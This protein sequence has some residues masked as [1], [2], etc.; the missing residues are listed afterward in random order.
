MFHL[1][2]HGV[3]LPRG[4]RDGG[5][6]SCLTVWCLRGET[7]APVPAPRN[8]CGHV[9]NFCVK[10]RVILFDNSILHLQL[11][12]QLQ[13]HPALNPRSGL[14]SFQC[15]DCWICISRFHE[16]EVWHKWELEDVKLSPV[17]GR[18][19]IPS[20]PPLLGSDCCW[21]LGPRWALLCWLEET[22][23]LWWKSLCRVLPRS[24]PNPSKEDFPFSLC[25]WPNTGGRYA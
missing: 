20:P 24:L 11:H 23:G 1:Y 22:K 16:G 9:G 7:C 17:K 25:S 15:Q 10:C 21:L 19:W 5:Y 13:Y 3:A 2:P 8:V 4:H 12:T 14:S 6:Q 18:I